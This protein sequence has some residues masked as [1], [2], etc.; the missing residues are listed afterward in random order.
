MEV[1]NNQLLMH[2]A[3]LDYTLPSKHETFVYHLY[4]VG[5]TSKTLYKYYTNVCVC[6]LTIKVGGDHVPLT[7]LTLGVTQ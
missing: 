7:L 3:T 6:W 5:P 2:M 1:Q 4:N